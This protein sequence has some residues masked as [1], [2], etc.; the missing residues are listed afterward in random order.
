[1]KKVQ[2][3]IIGFGGIAESRIAKEG[4]CADETRF[5]AHPDARL[6]GATDVNPVRRQAVQSLGLQWYE[7]AESLLDQADIEAVFISTDNR[8]HAA[9]AKAAM[10]RGKHCLVEKPVATSIDDLRELQQMARTKNLILGVDHMMV[11][12]AYNRRARALVQEGRIGAVN[13]ICL[14]MEFL[15]GAT[16]AEA[17]S[18]RCADP[19]QLG[20]PIGDVGSHCLYMAEFL[21][22]TRI[23]R[24]ACVYLTRTLDIAVENGAFIGFETESGI[25][26]SAR[27]A[28][29]QPRGAPASTLLNLGYEIYGSAG[30]IRGYGTLFQLSGHPDEPV[31]IHLDVATGGGRE[32]IRLDTVENIY[33]AAISHHA[34]A[35]RSRA[36]ID[37]AEA[38][39]NLTMI[40]ACHES[41]GRNGEFLEISE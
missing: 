11:H 21:L 5:P 14:H 19:Q 4:F 32:T 31:Q 12:N 36:F 1:M 10:E 18:W 30:V 26:G 40:K 35:I 9:V 41:A 25:Q 39:H 2:Y 3:G 29:N 17:A 38:L 27:V 7:S 13:D 33:Q 20:G 16:P 22:G 15:Y 6:T 8:S 34:R 28:F 23:R 24:L 37:G